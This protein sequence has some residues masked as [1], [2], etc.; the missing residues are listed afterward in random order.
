M[1]G[2]K[3]YILL[4]LAAILIVGPV[5]DGGAG[6]NVKI[7]SADVERGHSLKIMSFN[8]A[9]SG[10]FSDSW[11]KRRGGCVEMIHT[12]RPD[13]LGVQE[14]RKGQL[15]YIDFYAKGYRRVGVGRDNGGHKGE[16]CAVYYDT[17]RFSLLRN[18]DFWLSETPDVPSRGWDAAKKRVVTWVCLRDR[19]TGHN[20][21]VFNTHLDYKGAVAQE[22]SVRLLLERMNGIVPE[23]AIAIVS[24]DLNVQSDNEVLDPLKEIMVCARSE[25]AESD[26]HLSFNAWGKDRGQANIDFIFVR[27]A[28]P[29]RFKTHTGDYG[30]GRLISD[31][32]PIS[33]ELVY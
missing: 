6:A 16:H 15:N 4:T 27:H 21:Y 29:V 26:E 33:A 11:R 2:Y 9:V 3:R 30:S 32:Y 14:A 24:G 5:Y 23:D 22:E 7:R 19:F 13:I 8:I 17:E 12:E 1:G 25:A 20:L 10:T 28:T 31:H 18:G